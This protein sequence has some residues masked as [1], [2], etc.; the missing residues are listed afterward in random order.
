MNKERKIKILIEQ[1]KKQWHNETKKETKK[2]R[3]KKFST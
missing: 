1:R 2:G 3:K